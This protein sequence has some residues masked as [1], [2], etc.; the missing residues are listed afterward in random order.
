ML[1]PRAGAGASPVTRAAALP[2]ATVGPSCTRLFASDSKKGRG[3]DDKVVF[4]QPT[5]HIRN[6]HGAKDRPLP[7]VARAAAVL[8]RQK[9]EMAARKAAGGDDGAIT[10]DEFL[11]GLLEMAKSLP[12]PPSDA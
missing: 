7:S 1:L 4:K 8:A 5:Q 11:S 9:A 6:G 12:K 10:D 2:L 3:K